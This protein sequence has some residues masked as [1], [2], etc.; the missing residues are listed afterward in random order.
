MGRRY[1]LELASGRGVGCDL[2]ACEEQ[3]RF[4]GAKFSSMVPGRSRP[5]LLFYSC[6]ASFF[7]TKLRPS[8]WFS[9]FESRYPQP[10]ACHWLSGLERL[11]TDS[12][13]GGGV[14]RRLVLFNLQ[15]L[16]NLLKRRCSGKALH[17]QHRARSFTQVPATGLVLYSYLTAC[18]DVRLV[19]TPYGKRGGR[20]SNIPT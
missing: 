1:C 19:T 9:R 5:V 13:N 2:R 8:R 4:A 15:V 14:F 11:G 10:R 17:C 3:P 20:A 6:S 18:L 12:A 7:G 16:N